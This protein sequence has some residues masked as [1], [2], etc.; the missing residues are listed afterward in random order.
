[1][2]ATVYNELVRLIALGREHELHEAVKW[3]AARWAE[4]ERTQKWRA[5]RKVKVRV[6]LRGGDFWLEESKLRGVSKHE[7]E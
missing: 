4:E 2:S 7:E 5:K 6:D 3:V 1:V